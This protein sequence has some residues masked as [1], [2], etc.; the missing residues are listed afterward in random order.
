MALR[1]TLEYRGYTAIY[2]K[3]KLPFSVIYFGNFCA[4]KMFHL[5][6]LSTQIFENVP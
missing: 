1:R 3:V 2:V 4:K 6:R 5:V